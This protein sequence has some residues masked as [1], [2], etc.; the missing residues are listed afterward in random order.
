MGLQ[1]NSN[2]PKEH[3]LNSMSL[4]QLVVHEFPKEDCSSTDISKKDHL[5]L[6]LVAGAGMDSMLYVLLHSSPS[7]LL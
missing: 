2:P 5:W 7:P 4:D 3:K 6:K 1:S